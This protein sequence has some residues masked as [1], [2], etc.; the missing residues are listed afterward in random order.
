M[1]ENL[2]TILSGNIMFHV[3]E[4]LLKGEKRP[5]LMKYIAGFADTVRAH[6]NA[7]ESY[8]I[9]CDEYEGFYCY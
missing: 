6:G 7:Q 9:G 5:Y 4:D 1:S 3:P 2:I 8:T